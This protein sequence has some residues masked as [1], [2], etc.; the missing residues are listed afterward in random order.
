MKKQKSTETD[1][2]RLESMNENEIDY[3]DS[4]ATT[5]EFWDDAEV[6]MP[7]PKKHISLRL[8]EDV[9]AFFKRDGNGY[10]TKINAVLKTYVHS[11]SNSKKKAS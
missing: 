10:Q 7:A 6:M 9:I 2:H 1:F 3:S 11:H 4:P 8:D 5:K